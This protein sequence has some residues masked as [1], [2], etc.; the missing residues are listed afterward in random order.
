MKLTE[1]QNDLKKI[2]LEV[3]KLSWPD[4]PIL[5]EQMAGNV[6]P[7]KVTEAEHQKLH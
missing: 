1:I 4:K 5:A 7:V 6:C 2:M 3:R